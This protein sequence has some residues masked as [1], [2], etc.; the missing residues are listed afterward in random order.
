MFCSKSSFTNPST[1]CSYN[2]ALWKDGSSSLFKSWLSQVTRE[3]PSSSPL[4]LKWTL[5]TSRRSHGE[6]KSTRQIASDPLP[7]PLQVARHSLWA[8]HVSN[9]SPSLINKSV[10]C[11]LNGRRIY[12]NVDM[13]ADSSKASLTVLFLGIWFLLF[14]IL[15]IHFSLLPPL[16]PDL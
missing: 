14:F 13:K 7:F 10:K 16:S 9:I 12:E 6:W 1:I 4:E 15:C 5:I 11:P 3:K 8:N 2:K